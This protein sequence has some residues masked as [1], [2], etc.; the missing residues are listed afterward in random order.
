V[1]SSRLTYSFLKDVP[2]SIKIKENLTRRTAQDPQELGSRANATNEGK[3]M[4][5]FIAPRK[6]G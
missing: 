3:R 6:I 1:Q 4:N 5:M 2:L